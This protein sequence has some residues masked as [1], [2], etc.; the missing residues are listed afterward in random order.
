[1]T[2]A[3]P[4]PNPWANEYVTLHD[5]K[6]FAK[7]IR[8]RFCYGEIILDD[9]SEPK[10]ITRILIRV[11]RVRVADVIKAV[12]GVNP[13]FGDAG[14]FTMKMEENTLAKERRQPLEAGSPEPNFPLQPLEGA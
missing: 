11:K 14:L 8:S 4:Y 10:V 5:T 1:M 2:T 12:E 6:S 9:H 13:G 7:V 3:R